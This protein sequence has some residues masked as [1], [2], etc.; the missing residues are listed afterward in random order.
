MSQ[1]PSLT[2]E[3]APR[4][5]FRASSQLIPSVAT[6]DRPMRTAAMEAAPAPALPT[7][8]RDTM[9]AAQPVLQSLY[10]QR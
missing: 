5:P 4:I 8:K 3:M 10:Q 1:L 2:A 9:G 7:A 6:L